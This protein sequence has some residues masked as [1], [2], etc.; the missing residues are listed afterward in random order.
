MFWFS[1]FSNVLNLMYIGISYIAVS[2]QES[3]LQRN[4]EM[5]YLFCLTSDQCNDND[6]KS[7]SL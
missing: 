4:W 5:Y 7:F 2:I 6:E 1:Y 3:V